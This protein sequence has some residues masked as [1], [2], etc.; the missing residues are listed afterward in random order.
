MMI[1][2]RMRAAVEVKRTRERRKSSMGWSHSVRWDF[3]A[4]LREVVVGG[5]DGGD[6]LGIL[7]DKDF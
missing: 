7:I 5:G 3:G 1:M 4:V 6:G 2:G